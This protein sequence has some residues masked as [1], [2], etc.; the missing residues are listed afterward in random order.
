MWTNINSIEF[1]IENDPIL[2]E[3]YKNY[4]PGKIKSYTFIEIYKN[5]LLLGYDKDEINV[6]FNLDDDYNNFIEKFI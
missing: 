5:L 6:Y 2:L 1:Q 3:L 4:K